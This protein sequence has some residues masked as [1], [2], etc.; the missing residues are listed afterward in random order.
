MYTFDKRHLQVVSVFANCRPGIQLT[1]RFTWLTQ[2]YLLPISMSDRKTKEIAA[3]IWKQIQLSC[4]SYNSLMTT[5]KC[6]KMSYIQQN[7]KYQS[8]SVLSWCKQ[9]NRM[10]RSCFFDMLELYRFSTGKNI[11]QTHHC[12]V[13]CWLNG[14]KSF[15]V[16]PNI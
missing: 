6:S 2:V 11:D 12:C 10:W 15:T 14:V 9:T 3:D 13:L 5:R 4:E 16:D 8:L 1:S 7:V